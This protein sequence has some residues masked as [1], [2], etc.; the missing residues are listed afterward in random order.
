MRRTRRWAPLLG[1]LGLAGCLGLTPA[2]GEP[3]SF[4]ATNDGILRRGAELPDSGE[5]FVRARPGG[6]TRF[7]TPRLVETLTRTAAEV[8]RRFPGTA[9]VRIGDLSSPGGGRHHRHG[10][11]RTGRDA[12]VLFYVV[13][14]TG[15]SHTGRGWLAYNRFGFAVEHE[16]PDPGPSGGLFFFDDARNWHFVRT[17]LLDREA[18]VQWIFVSRGVKARL[19][20]YAI[21][22]ERDPRALSRAA[23]VLHQPARASPHDDHFHVRIMCSTRELAAGCRNRGPI[24][25]WLRGG[26][27]KPDAVDGEPLDDERLVRELMDPIEPEPDEPAEPAEPDEG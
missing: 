26:M 3:L 17:L 22:H 21:A 10:S 11:H 24:W 20:R 9:P 18:A 4:G 15:R 23:Y 2:P 12:D 19:L 16:R 7:G 8:A 14:P 1:A 25:P 6:P 27:E 13:D 5:G